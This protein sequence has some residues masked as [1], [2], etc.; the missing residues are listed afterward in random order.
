[1][2]DIS[3]V[4]S[5]PHSIGESSYQRYYQDRSNDKKIKLRYEENHA[6][7]NLYSHRERSS[8]LPGLPVLS[9]RKFMPSKLITTS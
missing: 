3:N 1:M 4:N 7:R 9:T 5:S 8:D 2:T 6:S